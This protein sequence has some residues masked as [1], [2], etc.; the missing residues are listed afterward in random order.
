M[1]TVSILLMPVAFSLGCTEETYTGNEGI[2]ASSSETM[3]WR[4]RP[5]N[6]VTPDMEPSEIQAIIDRGGIVHFA[7]GTYRKLG[8]GLNSGRFLLGRLGKDVTIVGDGEDRTVI[9]G[10]HNVFSAGSEGGNLYGLA[11]TEFFADPLPKVAVTIEG[12]HFVD[13]YDMAIFVAASSGL[14]VSHCTFT[15]P[16]LTWNDFGPHPFGI[17]IFV[18]R[19]PDAVELDQVRSEFGLEPLNLGTEEVTGAVEITDNT[20]DGQGMSHEPLRDANGDLILDEDGNPARPAWVPDDAVFFGGL[21]YS[22]MSNG[23]AHMHY[24]TADYL[25]ADNVVSGSLSTGISSIDN[26]GTIRI[27]RNVVEASEYPSWYSSGIGL[28]QMSKALVQHNDVTATG[29]GFWVFAVDDATF[30]SNRVTM[31]PSDDFMAGMWIGYVWNS[32]IRANTITGSSNFAVLLESA[33]GNALLG[34]NLTAFV[35]QGLPPDFDIVAHVAFLEG[36]NDNILVGNPVSVLDWG[37]GNVVT[38][39]DTRIGRE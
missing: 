17:G 9:E 29:D 11:Q 33:S 3:A 4:A 20:F 25:I 5:H 28:T 13:F 18:G 21:W 6:T 30:E 7:E 27:E 10:G 2:E 37:E 15:R 1:K 36:S 19:G 22:G 38:A 34:N 24:T 39:R 16:Q 26:G 23:F 14:K 31:L 12:I 35:P 8:S 32:T